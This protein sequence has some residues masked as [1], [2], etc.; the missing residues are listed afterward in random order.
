MSICRDSL[1]GDCCAVT[2][3]DRIANDKIF[4]GDIILSCARWIVQNV[5][6]KNAI[7][8]VP[9]C[10]AVLSDQVGPL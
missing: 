6:E 10:H 8:P 3:C 9:I 7:M 4:S 2:D 5:L 1:V